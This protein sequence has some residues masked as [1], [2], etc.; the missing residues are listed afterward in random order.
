MTVGERN[1]QGKVGTEST[2]VDRMM[3]K[4]AFKDFVVKTP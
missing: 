4:T 2:G 1:L 3:E